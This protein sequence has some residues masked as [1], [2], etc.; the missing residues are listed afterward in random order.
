M[1]SVNDSAASVSVPAFDP[2][3]G[4]CQELKLQASS[5][6]A[7][8]ALLVEGATVPFIA[9]YRKEATG[10]LD[11]VAI[12]NI[13]E[14]R[15]YLLE[16][17]GRRASVLAEIRSQGKLTAALE[18]KLKA[19]GTKAELEDLY[20]P[21]KPKRR[22]RAVI[23][24]ERGLEPLADLL[25]AQQDPRGPAGSAAA[26]VDAAKE[27]PDV[28]AALAGARD[29]VAERI[30]EDAEVRRATR[31]VYFKEGQIE[32]G[33]TKEHQDKVTKFDA[34]ASFA[35]PIAN[36]PSHR[37]LAIRRGETEGV[38]RASLAVDKEALTERVAK[39]RVRAGSPWAEQMAL[40]TKDA[41]SRLLVPSVE[42][43][44][45]VELKLSADRAAIDVFAKN[46]RELL[47]SAPL[48][49][50]PVLGI[51][52]GQRTGCKCVVV[53][54]TGK[55]LEHETVYLVQG[56][57]SLARAKQTLKAMLARHPIVAIAVGNGTHGRE[58]EAFAK[59]VLRELGATPGLPFVVSVSEAGASIY[60]ASDVAR[61]EFPDLDLTIRGAI[62]IARRLQDPLAELVK[63]DPKSIGVGQYQHDVFQ[64]FL[65]KKLDEVVESCVNGVGVELNTASASLLSRVA[66][67][68]P[69]VA[70]R[71]VA[72]R[73]EK[74]AFKSRRALLA[75][76]GMGPKTFEQAAGFVRVR[77]GEHP[78]D[79]S[80][81]HPERYEL[82][83][84]IAK[85]LGVPVASLVGNAELVKRID[86]ARYQSTEVGSFTLDDIFAELLRPGRDPRDEFQPPQFRDD[87]RTL[88]DLQPGMQLEGVVT[89]VTAFGAFVDVGVHQDGL[90]HVSQLA[91]RFVK[92]PS[93]VVK[94]GDKVSVRV[95]E[96]DL[97][98]RRIALTRKS[99][100]QPAPAP[101]TASP[102]PDARAR[103]GTTKPAA[104]M[105]KPAETFR[106]NPFASHF[107]K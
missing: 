98:R 96:V 86:R 12:R 76:A 47:L 21:Y 73:N 72:H 34:Y 36:I 68:G 79:S 82:V 55:L 84:R 25:W 29:I 80:A 62:S 92:D 41:V 15:T 81:V 91:D 54:E 10:G 17:E 4:I 38:L 67:L 16:L 65:A 102:A 37:Y 46:L 7:V 63:L 50:R 83:E 43:D 30:A 71:I 23:A 78:L 88:E 104:P 57:A 18:A 27:V 89:N 99:G 61:E 40:A 9:R 59:D 49:T 33:K 77:G 95:L 66:G 94:V 1:T 5:V 85:D 22:T 56:D 52:P 101:G 32:V 13:D 19:A 8:V 31:E 24:K 3:P 75:V 35:E 64:A 2:V 87:V 74:G 90:V 11:E 69:S 60:S 58:T 53:D 42:V 44:V 100:A 20:L 39:P 6:R 45:R 106:N 26:F 48:G 105:P 51:D 97:Q 14:R 70:K 103:K 28:A 107:R 93:E